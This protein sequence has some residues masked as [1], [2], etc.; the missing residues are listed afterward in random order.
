MNA[1]PLDVFASDAADPPTRTDGGTVTGAV[2]TEAADLLG[3]LQREADTRRNLRPDD[4]DDDEA[5]E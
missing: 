5:G 3:V 2:W 1:D 4:Y